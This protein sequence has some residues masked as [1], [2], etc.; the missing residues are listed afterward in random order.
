VAPTA[1]PS[2]A[3]QA[4]SLPPRGT[5][6]HR[7]A[8]QVELNTENARAL[9][10]ARETRPKNTNKS[11][12]PKQAEWRNFCG[13]K[14]FEDGELVSEKKVILFLTQKVLT[15]EIRK[16]RYKR[17]NRRNLE[18][19]VIKQTLGI[20]AIKL[21]VAAIVDVWSF[22]K[23]QG[24][25]P[26]PSPRGEALN[27]LLKAHTRNEHRRR[28][29]EFADRA[30]GT[31][32][33]G[34][35]EEKMMQ[36]VRICWQEAEQGQGQGYGRG[37]TRKKQ[38]IEA[39]LRTAVDFLLSHNLLLRS[40]SRLAAELPD[41]FSIMLPNEGPTPCP[42][43]VMI[44]DNGKTNQIGRLE[45]GA[46]IRHK[47]PLLCTM[48]HTAFYL[49]YRWNITGELPPCFRQRQLWYNLHLIK[50]EDAAKKMAY[51][52]QLEWINRMFSQAKV[53]SLKKTHAGR[54]Q[55]AKHAELKGVSEGQIRRAGRWNNDALTNCY[56]TH[57]PRKFIRSMA[58]FNPSVQ[59]NFYLPRAKVLPPQ[60]L[61][62]A[63]WPFVDEWISWFDSHVDADA[64]NDV[65]ADTD[66]R[67]DLAAQGFLRLL[68]E[69]RVILLQDSVILK[70][71]FPA[72]P[73]W[74][75]P[76]FTRADYLTFA[77][78]VEL[79]LLDM[80]EPEEIQIR[81]TLP[82][83]AERLSVIQ[84]SLTRDYNE[85]RSA[86]EQRLGKIESQLSNLF[87]GQIT[88][89][90]NTVRN[91]PTTTAAMMM[92]PVATSS[93]TTVAPIA[94]PVEALPSPDV[95]E[96]SRTISTVPQLWREWTE[97]I[98]GGPSVQRL[99]DEYG[100][101]WRKKH[102]ETVMFSRRKVII[103]EIRSR[104]AQGINTL[105]AVEEVEL[106]RQRAKLSLYQLYQFL[107]RNKKR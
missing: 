90:L 1:T 86:M 19:E 8:L 74:M 98:A 56:L 25:N 44:M 30:A 15:R 80:E 47:N 31:I 76:V 84:Q 95:Y 64:D 89:N 52:T 73:I 106:V 45:Y 17:G 22:Q 4:S 97:G 48:A 5:A 59:G 54:A 21:Y 9:A 105:A 37:G 35:D 34:Y 18:G 60:S 82:A 65:D 14:G 101:R 16:S 36:A 33:D 69:L 102:S 58:G 12:E 83:I 55:G 41:F 66:D 32:Q 26:Y 61:E 79:S 53:A 38:S 85:L 62:Q 71:E 20:S 57:L 107:N 28:R 6:E 100:P 92:A 72:H 87:E 29:L 91:H 24:I 67:K 103:D 78:Q 23:S 11:Y 49:F 27:G 40:E 13:D 99:E 39:Y 46:V 93:T 77:Q 63:V 68:R 42:L 7:A 51:D 43:M 70:R 2:P 75:D 104:Q 94:T 88:I 81:K 96:L 3:T 50:G 10:L